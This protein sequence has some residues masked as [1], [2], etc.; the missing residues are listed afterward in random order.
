MSSRL[1]LAIA[2][3]VAAREYTVWL[4][5]SIPMSDWFRMP[6]EGVT[7]VAWQVG[8]LAVAQFNL[9]LRR[10]RG[11]RHED[12]RLVPPQFVATFGRDSAPAAEAAKYPPPKEIREVFDAVHRQL[13]IELSS[14]P[15][16]E[17]DRPLEAPHRICKTKGDAL[18]WTSRH[19]MLH[20]GQIGL[21]R[22]LLGYP[23]L[24]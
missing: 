6:A 12:E 19:E 17:L 20:A 15:D 22:R 1:E 13:L 18:W 11:D 14:I 5:E 23:S 7:H 2:Q 21:V 9:S 16:A 10:I 8:H 3:V 4:V 24:W